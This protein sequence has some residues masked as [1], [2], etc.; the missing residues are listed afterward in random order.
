MN[1][2]RAQAGKAV[3]HSEGDVFVVTKGTK[4]T[5]KQESEDF[6][7]FYVIIDHAPEETTPTE[8]ISY[9]RNQACSGDEEYWFFCTGPDDLAPGS[10]TPTAASYEY[11]TTGDGV[12]SAGLWTCTA[13]ETVTNPY[14]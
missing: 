6:K 3:T 11:L 4:Y 14:P 12:F 13:H 2:V 1:Y 7:K 5:W 10:A 9:D 8:I